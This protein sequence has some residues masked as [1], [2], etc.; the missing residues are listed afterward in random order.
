LRRDT[1]GG[2]Q[3]EILNAQQGLDESRQA[4]EDTLVDQ[5]V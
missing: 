4:Y 1:T 2:N 3:V 5:A